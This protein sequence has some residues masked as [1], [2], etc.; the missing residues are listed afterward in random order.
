M[1]GDLA[2]TFDELGYAGPVPVFSPEE[3]R[4]FL[5][6][7][8]LP[9]RPEPLRWFK[10]H[11]STDRLF[12]A[13]ATDPRVV[14]PVRSLLGDDVIL[15][16]ASLAQREP[17]Q[18]HAWHTDI[19]SSDPRG[20]F[21]SVWI[22]LDNTSQESTLALVAR[23]HRVGE[24][25][26]KAAFDRGVRRGEAGADDVLGWARR[27]EPSAALV[28]PDVHD[29][30]AIFFDGRLWHR[31]HNT[32]ASGRRTALLL[33][34]AAARHHVR[35]PDLTNL[36]WPFRFRPERPPVVVVS[37]AAT[38]GANDVVP[39]PPSPER[40]GPVG[41]VVAH[42]PLPLPG[43][44]EVPWRPHGLFR[45]PTAVVPTM[46]CHVSVLAPGHS[47]H[48]PHV[49][50]E[51]E[52]LVVLDGEAEVMIAARPDDTRPRVERLTPGGFAYYPVGQ[53]H[54]IRNASAR[55][56]T[57]L[58]LKWQGPPSRAR[59]RLGTEIHLADLRPADDGRGFAP[60][61]VVEG[62]TQWLGKLQAHVT[63]LAP[64]AG[65]EPHAD[66]HDVAVL[67]FAGEI[68]T[69]G[70]RLRA[71]DVA[72]SSAGELHGI[73]NPGAVPA[74]YLVFE[75]HPVRRREGVL[76]R[77]RRSLTLGASQAY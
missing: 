76:A 59:A 23:S 54:T 60:A 41:N 66:Q 70:A 16:G 48:P 22:G 28:Q 12:F 27:S 65:Y 64:Q 19:E 61:L 63:R 1:G 30:D 15:W 40:V 31:S 34:Y 67:V 7:L 49:H 18:V 33:Q 68:E 56:V 69:L 8:E 37:G 72:Y 3:C 20:G 26:Q 52:I 39:P 55:P 11:A 17:G 47:P 29:G 24:P 14:E 74:V 73:R 6:E 2:A 21:V 51:E 25:L 13:L 43:T 62:P 36:E 38:N 58:M 53:H 75:F 42:V 45:G 77:L 5:R 46:S 4:T 71:H 50:P 32:R 57:Y 10:G 35:I 9:G 44:G